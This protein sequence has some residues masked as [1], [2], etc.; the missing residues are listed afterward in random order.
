MNRLSGR[1]P[2]AS[3]R[4]LSASISSS[5]RPHSSYSLNVN[6]TSQQPDEISNSSPTQSDQ[7]Q[8]NQANQT[9]IN[10][11]NIC[12][13]DHTITPTPPTLSLSTTPSS[14]LIRKQESSMP[15]EMV[16][17]RNHMPLPPPPPILSYSDHFKSMIEQQ[18]QQH[19]HQLSN[20]LKID[21]ASPP[22]SL[23]NESNVSAWTP[24][25]MAPITVSTQLIGK[26]MSTLGD[27]KMQSKAL[28][29]ESSLD[30]LREKSNFWK[31]FCY[32]CNCLKFA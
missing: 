27:E 16:V 9:V 1:L 31:I 14:L 4:R 13:F 15:P 26:S 32:V 2:V 12:Y 29:N 19:Q 25:A 22:L 10:S 7:H 8:I 3:T 18:Q 11:T 5:Q 30:T 6:S 23:S 24:N 20:D 21:D 17:F 28:S